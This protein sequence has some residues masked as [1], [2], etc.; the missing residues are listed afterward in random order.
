[1]CPYLARAC[2][3]NHLQCVKAMFES[4][5]PEDIGAFVSNS[6]DPLF[7]PIHNA[8]FSGSIEIVE[9]LVHHGADVNSIA[10]N[11]MTPLICAAKANHPAT[12]RWLVANGADKSFRTTAKYYDHPIGSSASDFCVG[13]RNAEKLRYSLLPSAQTGLSEDDLAQ[14]LLEFIDANGGWINTAPGLGSRMATLDA[15]YETHP[16]VCIYE[17]RAILGV[18]PK[19]DDFCLRY[20]I[21]MSPDGRYGSTCWLHRL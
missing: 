19:R 18:V 13:F 1:M 8:A 9:L 17:A 5:A 11:G 12:C 10:S 15:F 16:E 20:G 14:K 7:A 4:V 21:G 3:H 6:I 2:A